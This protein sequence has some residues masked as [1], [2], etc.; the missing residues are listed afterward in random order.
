MQWVRKEVLEEGCPRMLARVAW[1]P[2]LWRGHLLT[3]KKEEK[4]T[5]QK[6]GVG[7]VF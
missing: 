5:R 6:T 1:P 2:S 4:A 3:L 7:P